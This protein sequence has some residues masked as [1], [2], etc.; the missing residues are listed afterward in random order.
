MLKSLSSLA[1]PAASSLHHAYIVVG[2]ALEIERELVETFAL[3]GSPDYFVHKDSVFGIDNARTLSEI[4]FRKA[5]TGKKFFLIAPEKLTLEAQ[6]AL[7][8]TF[9]DPAPDTHFFLVVRSVESIL[10]TLKSRCQVLELSRSE[11]VKEAEKF[12]K[13]SLKERLAFVKKFVDAE[14]NVSVFLDELLL[15]T[16]SKPVYKLRLVSDARGVSPRLILEHLALVL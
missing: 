7:L 12:M 11:E 2:D 15:L 14:K 10:P 16:R 6:N 13:L 5:F 4:S 3:S 1:L 9:E 8:K